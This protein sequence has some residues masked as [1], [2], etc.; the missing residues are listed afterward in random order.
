V[1]ADPSPAGPRGRNT[2]PTFP[3]RLAE[4]RLAAGLS[5]AVLARAA[6]TS[7]SAVAMLE[8]GERAPSLELA[9]RLADVL[10][11]LVDD[12]RRPP[13]EPPARRKRPAKMTAGGPTPEPPRRGRRKAK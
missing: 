12:L 10:G 4:L 13:G 5:R 3:A 1:S 8:R 2:I 11:V 9:G 6:G 7:E